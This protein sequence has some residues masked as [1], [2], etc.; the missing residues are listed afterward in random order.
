MLW[1]YGESTWRDMGFE[2]T[3]S[4]GTVH[5]VL[6]VD[7]DVAGFLQQLGI[8]GA[9][10]MFTLLIKPA[11]VALKNSKRAREPENLLCLSLCG[12]MLAF[13]FM[14]TNVAIYGWGQQGFWMFIIMAVSL[15]YPKWATVN[16]LTE[17]DAITGV[18][19]AATCAW[20]R[21]QPSQ[22]FVS[23]FGDG[24]QL[25]K[26]IRSSISRSVEVKERWTDK[27]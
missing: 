4:N 17:S 7:S 3:W 9:L 5:P 18:S 20:P 22:T 8:V 27:R 14:T 1:G 25:F 11:I 16:Q 6:S 10:I 26:S 24:R 21:P 13:L 19:Q 23:E 15:T 12:C 2:E